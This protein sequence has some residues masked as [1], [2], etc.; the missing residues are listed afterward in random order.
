MEIT[1]DHFMALLAELIDENPL[2]CQSILR[3]AGIE[4]DS[5]IQTLA[6]TLQGKP[7]LLIN[8]D[9]IRDH[10]DSEPHVKAL[11]VHEFLHVILNH[12]ENFKD[13][14]DNL[15]LA[16]DAVVNAIIHRMLGPEYSDMMSQYYSKVTGRHCFLRPMAKEELGGW[17]GDSDTFYEAWKKLYRGELVVD[18]ILEIV[19]MLDEDI[20]KDNIKNKMKKLIK[21]REELWR[22]LGMGKDDKPDSVKNNGDIEEYFENKPVYLGNHEGM[23]E[24]TK[25]TELTSEVKKAI[26][27]TMR[28]MNGNGIWRSPKDR[29]VGAHEYRT[30]ITGK[31]E[32]M[33]LW[34]RTAWEALRRCIIPDPHSVVHD[35]QAETIRLPVLNERDKRGFLRAMWNPLLLDVTWSVFERKPLGSTQVYLDVSGSMHAEMSRIIGLLIRLRNYIRN[36]F[37]AFSDEVTIA[38][39][40][41]G[42]LKTSTSSGTS[43]NAVLRHLAETRPGR[44][45]IITD[46]Y[47]EPCIPDLLKSIGNQTIYSIISRDGSTA[48]IAR[49]GIPYVQLDKCPG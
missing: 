13:M 36:P 37:W 12:T 27:K 40:E 32:K 20:K 33:T 42:Q 25:E 18:D 8:L 45:V 24:K 46:G 28:S 5:E 41:K 10:C 39:I 49:A 21:E 4:F 30:V 17:K 16:L 2:A 22:S 44:A 29:G 3:I 11:V 7:K 6:M 26:E 23:F 48:E 1:K 15:N 14:T 43:I 9:F 47:I 38:K 35:I 31:D 34:E 19:E